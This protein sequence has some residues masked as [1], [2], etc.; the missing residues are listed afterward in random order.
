MFENLFAKRG[1][2]L[3]RLR[4]FLEVAE[5]GGIAKAVG[6]DPV[7]QSQYSRQLKELA[8]H[9]GLELFQRRG[10]GLRLTAAG[11]RLAQVVHES[12]TGLQDFANDC[13][14]EPI[15][16]CIG[17]GDSLI[18]WLL[19]PA[20]GKLKD[21]FP[22]LVFRVEN[23][24]TQAIVSGLQ[25]RSLDFGVL[26][27]DA[28]PAALKWKPL[29]QVEYALFVPR[30][31]I[32]GRLSATIQWALGHLPVATQSSDGQFN[33]QLHELAATLETR[34]NVMLECE[35]FPHAFRALQTGS[36]AA[37]L[38]RLAGA[39]LDPHRFLEIAS[40]KFRRRPVV[41]AWNPR[42]LR[43]RDTAERLCGSLSEGLRF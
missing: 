41:L 27:R 37:I 6:T 22:K 21:R 16:Y 5:A 9:F 1:L 20:F 18:Q 12:F 38:P 32:P 30:A 17:A 42:T 7:R 39:D 40:P 8:E 26:R 24:R 23:L 4:V 36:F 3:D 29:G 34:L 25:E 14:G 19:M 35:T 33:Q 11:K 15:R 10:K 43:L 31:L 13:T 28:V 2:S